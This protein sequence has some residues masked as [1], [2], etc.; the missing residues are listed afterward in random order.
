MQRNIYLPGGVKTTFFFFLPIRFSLMIVMSSL[1]IFLFLPLTAIRISAW[2]QSRRSPLS[3]FLFALSQQT[4]I[5]RHCLWDFSFPFLDLSCG[6]RLF[7]CSLL[8]WLFILRPL[9]PHDGWC[10]PVLLHCWARC[11]SFLGHHQLQ[12]FPFALF[13]KMFLY[14][15]FPIF[16]WPSMPSPLLWELAS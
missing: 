4:V 15:C 12:I 2:G 11:L 7:G 8:W 14:P 3:S 1:F 16:F 9:E 13:M 5:T 10:H 6:S